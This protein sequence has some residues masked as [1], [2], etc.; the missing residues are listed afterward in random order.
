MH[1][2]LSSSFGFAR[3]ATKSNNQLNGLLVVWPFISHAN[4]HVVLRPTML[5]SHILV[6]FPISLLHMSWDRSDGEDGA[7][8]WLNFQLEDIISDDQKFSNRGALCQRWA[9]QAMKSNE[10]FPTP[11]WHHPSSKKCDPMIQ[12]FWMYPVID[13]RRR[14]RAAESSCC[15]LGACLLLISTRFMHDLTQSPWMTTLNTANPCCFSD[16][17]LQVLLRSWTSAAV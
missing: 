9:C 13:R 6:D 15:L 7:V 3:R 11:S 12:L 14:G 2:C 10:I 16:D 8:C 4:K 5:K 1:A 17:S